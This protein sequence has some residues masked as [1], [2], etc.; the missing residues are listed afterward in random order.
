MSDA[1]PH[2]VA[3]YYAPEADD[4]LWDAGTR[5][6]G[7]DPETGEDRLQ[8]DGLAGE[9]TAEAAGYG[10]HGTLKPPMRLAAGREFSDFLTAVEALARALRAFPM[11]PLSVQILHGFLAVR[12]KEPSAALQALAD[13][14][15]ATLDDFREPPS[16]AELA[17]RRRHGLTPAEEAML[18]RWGYPYV[19]QLWRFHLTLSRRLTEAEAGLWQPRAEA[20]FAAALARPRMCRSL[21]VFTQPA[22]GAP[23][24]LA[25]RLPFGA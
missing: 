1:A 7:C 11:P 5:W 20:F 24:R 14:T 6:L 18:Q 19:F 25:R 10:L 4:P 9:M 13:V 23:F 12:E 21:A 22:P 16:E 17:R 15:V 3:V 8:P 2:R